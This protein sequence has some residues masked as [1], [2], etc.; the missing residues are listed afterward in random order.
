M[1]YAIKAPVSSVEALGATLLPDAT[2]AAFRV[3]APH[4]GRVDV[5]LASDDVVPVQTL[6]LGQDS[7]HPGYWSAEVSGV[8]AGHR[9]QFAI[10]NHGGDRYDPGGD[11]L[12]RVDPCARQVLASAPDQPAVVVDPH[13]FVFQ[14]PFRTPAFADFIITSATWARSPDVAMVL[15]CIGTEAAARRASTR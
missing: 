11:P 10:T 9:Y 5:L 4:A 6:P 14:A 12:L 8:A 7:A 1:M 15:P 2:G 3:W 13:T